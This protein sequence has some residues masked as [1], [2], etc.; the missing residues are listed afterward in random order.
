MAAGA[1]ASHGIRRE[2]IT[3]MKTNSTG[4]PDGKCARYTFTVPGRPVP[5]A[6]MTRRGKWVAPQAQRYLDY[7]TQVAWTARPLFPAL[8]GGPLAVTIA[9]YIAGRG[10][11]DWDNYGKAICDSLN[12]VAWRD[13]RQIQ[14]GHVSIHRVER[15]T[16]QR[17]EVAITQIAV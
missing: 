4:E 5:A 15:A 10:G 8:L 11:G 13:D 17:A 14:E 1:Q 9:V 12:G 3:P 6:R 7:K 2:T 16:E